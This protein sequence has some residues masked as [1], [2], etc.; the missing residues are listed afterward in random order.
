MLI[1]HETRTLSF[2]QSWL[3][4][5]FRCPEEARFNIVNPE[6]ATV[7]SDEAIIGT[8]AHWGIEQVI[9][10]NIDASEI[11]DAV[12]YF[13]TD[14][15]QE[16]FR[17]V[18]RDSLAEVVDYAQRCARAWVKDIM[19]HAPLEGALTEQSF[20]VLVGEYRDWNVRIKGTVDLA[21]AS[22]ELWDWK[23][24]GR[25]YKQKEKQKWAIQPTIYGAAAVLGGIRDD[26]DYQWPINFTYGVMVKLVK[27]CRGQM[28]TVQ[29]T[30]AH[31]EWAK[32]RIHSFVDLFLD[33]GLEKSW[34]LVEESNWLCSA[35]WCDFYHLCRGAY[36][37]D[38]EDLFGWKAA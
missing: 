31:W 23:T 4:G 30:E 37:H 36:L 13:F 18:K 34:P 24:S 16:E 1:D 35:T 9:D 12:A 27:Q 32:K 10:G 14:V 28:I 29:R 19:P 33:F 25:D 3:D 20:D 26:V 2:R 21:P 5:A 15:N 17:F 6:L 7:T 8:G 11:E 22:P 38:G